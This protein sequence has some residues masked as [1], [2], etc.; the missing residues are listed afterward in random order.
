ME[1]SSLQEKVFLNLCTSNRWLFLYACD[2]INI[3]NNFYCKMFT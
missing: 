1:K 2:I 3:W